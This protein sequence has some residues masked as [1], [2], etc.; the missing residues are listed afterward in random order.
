MAINKNHIKKIFLT[1][2]W[3]V[4]AVLCVWLLVA[5]VGRQ[6]GDVCK[7]V[8]I[9]VNGNGSNFFIDKKDVLQIINAQNGGTTVGKKLAGINLRQLETELRK[10]TW[11][12]E[13][14]IYFD[15]NKKLNVWLEERM[16]VARIFTTTQNSFYIDSSLNLLPLSTKFSA[17]LPVFTN[18]PGEKNGLSKADS[19]L[20]K[21]IKTLSTAI[22]TDDYIMAMIDQVDINAAHQF[23]MI[24]KI[25]NQVILFGD[26]ENVKQKFDKLKVF[27]RGVITKVGWSKYSSINLQYKDQVVAVIRG[28]EEIKADSLRALALLEEIAKKAEDNALQD[29]IKILPEV[30]E[31]LI[32]ESIIQES[33]E[34]EEEPQLPAL[35]TSPEPVVVTPPQNTVAP[36]MQPKTA[37]PAVEKPKAVTKPV[38]TAPVKKPEKPKEKPVVK[39]IPKP[40]ATTEPRVPKAV[41]N[42]NK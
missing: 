11:V 7:E 22:A 30:K 2:T 1:L 38:V 17:R 23:E 32:D 4:V 39:P 27:Y 13:V 8:V 18:F 9:N 12:K 15:N 40:P 42:E 29:N 34:R 20:L 14:Q 33:I 26:A 10:D 35:T 6:Q 3:S 37:T 25:G 5:A 31:T 21:Q 16:P 36:V 28:K 19:N 24:P 41:M